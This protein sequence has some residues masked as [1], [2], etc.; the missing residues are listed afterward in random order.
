M[1]K[2]EL[3]LI[4]TG[5]FLLISLSIFAGS[6]NVQATFQKMYP[7]A[8]NVEWSKKHGYQIATFI[9]NEVGINA[10]FTN[11]AKWVMT[12]K[13]VNSLAAVPTI[14]AEKSMESTMAALRLRYVRI[15]ELPNNQPPVYEIGRAHV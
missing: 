3:S 6:P 7:N 5:L 10:W 9:E 1:K 2:S 11:K 4:I 13:D 8:S 14:V 12:S 15:V